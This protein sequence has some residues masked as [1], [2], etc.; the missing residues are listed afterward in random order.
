MCSCFVTCALTARPEP[1]WRRS[2]PSVYALCKSN[3]A[4]CDV[5]R[6]VHVVLWL[7]VER[8]RCVQQVVHSRKEHCG[9]AEELSGSPEVPR[10]SVRQEPQ[11]DASRPQISSITTHRRIDVT[12]RTDSW[13]YSRTKCWWWGQRKTPLHKS[14]SSG[15]SRTRVRQ[16]RWKRWQ[17]MQ[18]TRP[19]PQKSLAQ[20]WQ[21]LASST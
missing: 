2:E 15:R 6:C 20:N 8:A 3:C 19:V 11:S 13:V 14:G 5:C 17:T 12:C 1:F 18:S 4:A 21:T 10:E 16:W 9:R 7:A